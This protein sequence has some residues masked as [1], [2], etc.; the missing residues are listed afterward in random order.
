MMKKSPRAL[1]KIMSHENKEHKHMQ[2]AGK[3][4]MKA[5]DTYSKGGKCMKK[6]GKAKGYAAGGAAKI[7]LKEMT[8]DGKPMKAKGKK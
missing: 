4:M 8:Q 7:R 3:E 2:M 1:K 5:A 6:G